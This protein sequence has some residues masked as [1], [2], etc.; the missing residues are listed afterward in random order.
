MKQSSSSELLSD[1]F[2]NGVTLKRGEQNE[3]LSAINPIL[4]PC[5]IV[6]G[7][8]LIPFSSPAK[9]AVAVCVVPEQ[10]LAVTYG[11]CAAIG[12]TTRTMNRT[13]RQ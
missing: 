11:I 13:M 1:N 5:N 8:P 3:H 12:L 6:S 4:A 2:L 7:S 10:L 9:V